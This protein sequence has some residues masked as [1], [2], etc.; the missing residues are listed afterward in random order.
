M[1]SRQFSTAMFA[2]HNTERNNLTADAFAGP[3][4]LRL[5]NTPGIH[6]V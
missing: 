2:Y 1:H 3:L 6:V 4:R 5:I